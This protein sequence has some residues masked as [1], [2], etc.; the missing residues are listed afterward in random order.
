MRIAADER[1]ADAVALEGASRAPD[2]W[3]R[4]LE[5]DGLYAIVACKR[6]QLAAVAARH[7]EQVAARAV[8]RCIEHALDSAIEVERAVGIARPVLAQGNV[9]NDVVGRVGVEWLVTAGVVR[10]LHRNAPARP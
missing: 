10:L 8:H 5:A 7:V 9:G 2:E 6:P 4:E 3:R 1:R